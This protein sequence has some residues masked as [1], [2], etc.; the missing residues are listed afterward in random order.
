[1]PLNPLEIQQSL[2]R[3]LNMKTLLTRLLAALVG[4][5]TSSERLLRAAEVSSQ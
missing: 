4:A 1:M 5:P 3:R 2:N